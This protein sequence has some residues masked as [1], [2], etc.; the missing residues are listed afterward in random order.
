MPECVKELLGHERARA[1][2]CCGCDR[3]ISVNM[4]KKK[5]GIGVVSM[6]NKPSQVEKVRRHIKSYRVSNRALVTSLCTSCVA[7]FTR[8]A[9]G[10]DKLLHKEAHEEVKKRRKL[11]AVESRNS[12][13]LLGAR[14]LSAK[15]A[16]LWRVR[17]RREGVLGA[18]LS[19]LHR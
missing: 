17:R 12:L 1:S 16:M 13:V 18:T 4:W 7:M 9:R 19:R 10:F 3:Y 2:L 15:R 8:R 14:L 11:P 6:L 5:S